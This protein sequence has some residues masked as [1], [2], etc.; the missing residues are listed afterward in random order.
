MKVTELDEVLRYLKKRDLIKQYIKAKLNVENDRTS[1]TKLRKRKPKS[2][3]VWYFRINRQYRA[4]CYREE[5]KLI[6]FDVDDH[7]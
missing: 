2:D 5:N 4:L 3:N 1:G 6:V 7:Q